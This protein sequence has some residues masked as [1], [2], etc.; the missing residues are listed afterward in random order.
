MS[1]SLSSQ[2]VQ[3]SEESVRAVKFVYWFR[4]I[5]LTINNFS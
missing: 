5:L 2:D 4:P 1:S 3:L